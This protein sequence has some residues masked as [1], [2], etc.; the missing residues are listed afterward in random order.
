MRASLYVAVTVL[1]A[2]FVR[3][4]SRDPQPQDA[5][6]AVLAAFDKYD[7][8]ALNAAHSNKLQDDFIFSLLR[9]P[10]L[11]GRVNDIAVECGN[12]RYQAVL[13]RY[14]AGDDVPI[15]EARLVWR[16]TTVAM[17]SVSGFYA[18]LFPL[19]REV[20]TG[21]PA[22][23]RFR[24]LALEPPVDWGAGD[25]S[26][27]LRSAG[28][29]NASIASVM[30]T[31][32]FAKKRKALVLCGVGHL[33]HTEPSRET[34]TSIYERAYPGRTFVVETHS[35]F[36]AFIDLDRGHQLE[37]RMQPW[38]RPSI[39]LIKGTWLADLDL[40]YF[41]WP[42]PKRMAGDAIADKADAYLYLGPGDSLIYEKTP[43]SILDDQSYMA[44]VSRRFSIDAN[45]LRRRNDNPALYTAADR[46]EARQFAPGAEFVGAYSTTLGGTPVVEIDF[47][48]G[49]LSAKL[50]SSSGWVTLATAGGPARYHADAS[51]QDVVL[52]FEI[53]NGTVTGVVLNRG[54]TQPKLKLQRR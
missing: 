5:T 31:E 48:A 27:V 54:S 10:A 32:V 41:M 6:K 13:D 38:P 36:A 7:V 37:A 4:Q 33:F 49:K 9:T 44:E 50:P 43:A 15:E 16:N 19:V 35:G 1:S 24:V 28:D 47:R 11:A 3:A 30:M 12:S 26:S 20:N 42:F 14:I 45:A 23:K 22:E 25:P 21:L 52:E 51:A 46:L 40:P 8:V 18:E 53:V 34:A 2:A 39:V 29:R 17:C